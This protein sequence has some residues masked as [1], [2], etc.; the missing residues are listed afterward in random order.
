MSADVSHGGWLSDKPEELERLFNAFFDRARRVAEQRISQRYQARVS[1]TDIAISALKSALMD[2]DGPP[3]FDSDDDFRRYLFTMVRNKTIDAI[4]R[5]DAD[6]REVCRT[7]G[8]AALDYQPAKVEV[9]YRDDIV[10]EV[11]GNCVASM[12]KKWG[13][14]ENELA[15]IFVSILGNLWGL[16]ASAILKSWQEE[17]PNEDAPSVRWIQMQVRENWELFRA[18][19]ADQV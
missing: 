6:K 15:G 8:G 11:A 4:R 3:Q 7:E 16:N 1:P 13:G 10:A 14:H 12:L 9:P 19:L 17:F 18:G 5:E 2:T